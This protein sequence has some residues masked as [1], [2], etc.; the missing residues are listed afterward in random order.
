MAIYNV[1]EQPVRSANVQFP[2]SLTY[3]R[4]F[5]VTADPGTA[6]ADVISA[7]G[8]PPY[9]SHPEYYWAKAT[10]FSVGP[11]Q[12]SRRH[13]EV[14]VSYS[15][16][17]STKDDADQNPLAQADVWS[18]STSGASVP[19]LVCYAGG[20]NGN[21]QPLTNTAGDYFEGLT[22]LEGELKASISGNRAS[23]PLAQALAYTN[24]VNDGPYMGGG[25]HTWLC[26]GISGQR[27]V[28]IVNDNELR[29]WAIT[30]ELVYRPSGHNLLLPNVGFNYVEN[31]KKLPCWVYDYD[32]EGR[33]TGRRIKATTAQKLT[34][35]GGIDPTVSGN[36]EERG[37]IIL[38]RRVYREMDFT[39]GFGTP[40]L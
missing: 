8:I 34:L 20:G 17:S 3:E 36:A 2:N 28:Q 21:I 14:T 6:S 24:S 5:V 30:A 13:Q 15:L 23:F 25:A 1:I 40:T 7:L 33:P 19:A 4:K 12:S 18:F 16:P 22:T 10:G 37:P 31:G 35:G 9:D 29:F 27:Q 39:S 11:Y 38:E 32:K 26:V